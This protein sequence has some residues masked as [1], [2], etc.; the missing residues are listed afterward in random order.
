[1]KITWMPV[2]GMEAE[3]PWCD[4]TAVIDGVSHV[5]DVVTKSHFE[6][7]R[8]DPDCPRF[9]YGHALFLCAPDGPSYRRGRGDDDDLLLVVPDNWY[10]CDLPGYIRTLTGLIR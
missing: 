4:G 5:C 7:E 8:N 6:S 10:A 2:H 9:G 3:G 1:M